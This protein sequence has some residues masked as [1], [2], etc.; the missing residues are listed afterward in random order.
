MLFVILALAAG[1]AVVSRGG[2]D[3]DKRRAPFDLEADVSRYAGPTP[4]V[5]R[6]RAAARNATG[7]VIYRWRF[8]DGTT[9]VLQNPTHRFAWAGYYKVI[10]DARDEAGN[11]KRLT[12]L[13][14][15]WPPKEWAVAHW[16][17]G[18]DGRGDEVGRAQQRR[19]ES[20]HAEIGARVRERARKQAARSR[21]FR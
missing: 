21:L 13:L 7:E 14:G 20:R 1:V 3:D 11:K 9:S 4:L 6:F 15:A 16:G 10:L 12:F 5:T 19:T 2:G 18:D 17:F 8:D